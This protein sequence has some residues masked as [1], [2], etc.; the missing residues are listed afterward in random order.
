MTLEKLL[1]NVDVEEVIGGGKVKV[2]GLTFNSKE[3]AA[4]NVFICVSGF[5]TDGHKYAADAVDAG[6]V[7]VVAEHELPDMEVPV[8]MVKNTRLATAQLAAAFYDYP[9]KRFKLIGVTGTNGKTTSTYLIKSI[10]EAQGKKVGLIGTNQNIIG[11]EIIPAKHTTPDSIELMQLF[12]KMAAG[13]ADYV[14]MEVSSHSLELERVAACEFEIAALTNITQDHLDFHKTMENYTLAKAKLFKMCKKAVV[15]ADDKHSEI[16][17]DGTSAERV[18]RY[19]INSECDIKADNIK[20]DAEG[21]EFDVFYDDCGYRCKIGIP[22]EFSVYNAL[23]ALSCC[24][25]AGTDPKRAVEALKYAEGVKGRVEV[26]KTDTDYTVIIDYAHTPD[27]LLN[28]IKTIRGFAKGR[29]I[30]VFGCGGDRDKTKRPKMGK[31]AGELSDFCVVTS[32][33]PRSEDEHAII[34]DILVGMRE[35]D[36]EYIVIEKRFAAIEYALDHAEADD[37]ILLAGKG[38]ETYQILKDRTIDFDEREIVL[39]LTGSDFGN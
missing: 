36:C 33:N 1:E 28:V 5:K 17:L 20:L 19:G 4:G 27:G 38:H 21:A 13:G 24:I 16:M 35:T 29:I 8:V 31:I 23:T 11:K 26:V 25:A 18:L 37:I 7:A 34:E 10:L 30:T 14:V 6:A 2:S 3:V 9:F 12:T 39:K 32:D 15:N 22:G